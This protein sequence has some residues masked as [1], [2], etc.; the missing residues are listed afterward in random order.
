MELLHSMKKSLTIL[1]INDLHGYIEAHPEM[2]RTAAGPDYPVLGG[3]ARIASLFEQVRRQHPGGVLALDNGDTFHGTYVAVQSRGK[4][5]VPLMN[6]LGL[7]AMTVHWEFAY[8]PAG[9]KA[10][11]AGLDYPI[12]AINCFDE[13]TGELVFAPYRMVE[14]GG[15]RVALI[16][17]ACNIVDKTMP[18]A[19]SEG[20]RFTVG[21]DEL[22]GWI[23]HVKQQEQAE[24]V[25]VLSHLGFPQDVKLASQVAGIDVLVSGHTHNRM[26]QPV[27][28]NGTIIFQSGCHGSFVGRLDVEVEHGRVTGHRHRLIAVDES[29]APDAR[30]QQKVDAALAPH[31]AMLAEVVGRTEIALDRYRMLEC[32]M[33]DLL[34]DAIAAA[35]GTGIAF[36]NGWRYGAP[37]RPGPITLD[38]LWNIIPTNPPV[39]TVELRGDEIRTMLEEN[40]ERTFAADPYAQMGGYMK[41][42]RGL[43][44]YVKIEN[45]AGHRIER[46][47]ALGEP[48]H[49]DRVYTVAFV[50][51]QGVPVRF[52]RNRRALAVNAI[53]ALRQH[54]ARAAVVG[55]S[56]RSVVAV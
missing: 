24:L 33:D 22:P 21:C 35:A 34:L 28:E 16:G 32:P 41:R 43:D 39:S 5:M 4:A 1:Q 15:L 6:D 49:A 30:M 26:E 38:D 51:A 54:L 50:T 52:G 53:D 55:R 12:L 46:L 40:L 56:A 11:A 9:V 17:I 18:P 36:S 25:V 14:R 10:L 2:I 27:I 8:G 13:K 19:F 20:V 48:I 3:L 23:A 42:C 45:P 47:F 7:D 29:L 44:V 37:I 31:R